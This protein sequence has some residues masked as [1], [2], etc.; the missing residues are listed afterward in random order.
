M[1]T[2][3]TLPNLVIIGAMKCA[4]TALHRYLSMHPHVSMA[5][6]K[7]MNFFVGP[8]V[9]ASPEDHT[10]HRGNWHRGVQW[11]AS[12]FADAPVRGEAS[13]GYT[14]PSFP[15]AAARMAE[16]L[17]DV[18]LIY[19]VRD[20]IDRALSQYAHHR[21]MGTEPRTLDDALLN[22]S[23]QY[24]ERS[25]YHARLRPYLE[26]F[27]AERIAIVLQEDLLAWRRLTLS[28]LYRF[29]G[30]D[31]GFWSPEFDKLLHV[32]GPLPVPNER[33]ERLMSGRLAED[34]ARLRRLTGR[35][36]SEW[37]TY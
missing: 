10:W 13:P 22:E 3:G 7:E 9:A 25:E 37:R 2:V 11:Y 8:S 32:G 16:M 31:D 21:R 4:T 24:I 18:R 30:V 17:P 28:S 6:P 1:T 14:S 23:S 34:V 33:L 29:A 27:P 19:L 15:E 12:H 36:L 20:P 35:H 26:R 5:A